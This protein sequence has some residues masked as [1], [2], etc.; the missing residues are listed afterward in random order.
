VTDWLPS[1]ASDLGAVVARVG[2][3][4]LF[5][6]Q[7]LAVAKQ[8]GKSPRNALEDLVE[9]NLLAECARGSGLK[10]ADSSDADVASTLVQRLLEKELEPTLRPEAMPDSVLRPMYDKARDRF[11]H[12]RL[13]EIGVLAL[14][15]GALMKES[16]RKARTEAAQALA[17]FLAAHPPQTLDEFA[18]VANDSKWSSRKVVF[19]HFLQGLDRPLSATVGVQVAKLHVPGDTTPM[20]VD[21]DGF[22]VARYIAERPPEDISFEQARDGLRAGYYE[23][24]R[25][26]RFLDFSTAF[27]NLHKVEVHFDLLTGNDQR[28]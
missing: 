6:T 18:A 26:Q 5:A 8:T 27:A 24:W 14:Y 3:V 11:V 15:T 20:I 16:P 12:S 28:P 23:H 25:K 1:P 10:P 7:V 17:A 19:A 13:V 22:F 2:G 21:E 9:F 4:P